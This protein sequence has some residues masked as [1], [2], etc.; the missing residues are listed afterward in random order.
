[1]S[2]PQPYECQGARGLRFGPVDPELERVLATL[3][4]GNPCEG[5]EIL[6][7]ERVWAWREWV[8]KR[9][10]PDGFHERW[11]RKSAALRAAEAALALAPV[12]TPQPL[13]ALDLRRGR[14]LECS[15]LVSERVRGERVDVAF[16]LDPN[17]VAAFPAFMAT[18]HEHGVMH[19]DLN[20]FN[21]LWDGERW[22]L[23]D[24]DGLRHGLHRGRAE[25]IAE[26]Q[27]ARLAGTL[28]D[29]ARVKPLFEAY[30]ALRRLRDP[31][32]AW[33]R[34][35]PRSLQFGKSYDAILERRRREERAREARGL[36]RD[37]TAP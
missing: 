30:A 28:R 16:D 17:S 26:L 18:M 20:V 8:L 36:D 21:A 22:Q 35:E 34:I 24:L 7:P 1:M 37:R 15:W 33:A 9:S 14:R 12:P 13:V 32:A 10:E 2:Q 23:I 25:R 19:G 4:A 5:A 31:A 11:L 3:I 6:K 27:W 29:P